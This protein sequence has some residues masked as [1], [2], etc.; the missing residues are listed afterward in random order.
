MSYEEK[1]TWAFGVIAVVGYGIYW[2]ILLPLI[3]QTPIPETPYV[4]PMIGTIV[5]AIVAGI[6]TGIGL[7]IFSRDRTKAD[8]RDKEIT[9]F[10]E[11]IG[12]SFIVLGGLGALVLAWVD[13]D[14]FWIANVLYLGFVLSA[15]L[16][17]I[18]R[19]VA[20]GRGLHAW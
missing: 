9:R 13:A 19:L 15:V 8:Q 5:G 4:L 7:G 16:S 2:C 10:G 14:T 20:Y 12:S 18:A 6:F 11:Q 3:A 17:V 1:N